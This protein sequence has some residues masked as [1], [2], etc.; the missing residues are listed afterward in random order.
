MNIQPKYITFKQNVLLK[1]KGFDYHILLQGFADEYDYTV[2]GS[3]HRRHVSDFSEEAYPNEKLWIP[4]P[5]QHQVIEWLRI[6]H[7]IWVSINPCI[8]Q[9]IFLK[10]KWYFSIHKLDTIEP[11][12]FPNYTNYNTPQ[13]AYS[14]AFDYVLNNL[15]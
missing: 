5:E 2:E 13:E 10:D 11:N 14:A 1:E 7:G 8:K 4:V 12:T 15:I 6:K 3:Y 9:D